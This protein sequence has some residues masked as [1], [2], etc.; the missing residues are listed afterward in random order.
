[1]EN[2]KRPPDITGPHDG[3]NLS[4]VGDTYR[5]LISGEQTGGT[6]ATIDMLIPPGGG[7]GPHAHAGFHESFYVIDGE[8]EVR[9][10]A[11]VF[12]AGK[13]S[14]VHIPTGGIVHCFKN[15]TDRTAHLLCM[16]APSG[17][18]A[19]FTEIGKP[20]AIGEFLAPPTMNEEAL[21]KLLPI[22]ERYG[23]KVFPPDYLG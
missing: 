3:K 13:G 12:A 9:S 23:Q 4:V 8:I 6:F 17:L 1:M 5:I 7:P 14:F 22:A 20:V 10:E 21:K 18:E 16:V 2:L 11:G 19:F 15:K